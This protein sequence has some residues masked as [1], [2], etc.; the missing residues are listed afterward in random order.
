MTLDHIVRIFEAILKITFLLGSS[1][2]IIAVVILLICLF[3]SLA[4]DFDKL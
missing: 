2:L 1:A 4:K 3:I